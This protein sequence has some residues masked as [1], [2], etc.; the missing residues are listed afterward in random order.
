MNELTFKIESKKIYFNVHLSFAVD[1]KAMLKF[2][3][4][5]TAAPYFS[6][7]VWFIGEHVMELDKCVKSASE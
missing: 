4:D 5:K 7:L 1:D 3:R 2:V 6:N